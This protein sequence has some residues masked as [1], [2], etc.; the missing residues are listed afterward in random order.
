LEAKGNLG[1]L[2]RIIGKEMGSKALLIEY[3]NG[4]M[5]FHNKDGKM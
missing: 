4:L 1:N 2:Y 3:Y 5:E